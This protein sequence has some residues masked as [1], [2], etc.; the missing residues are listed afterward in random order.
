VTVPGYVVVLRMYDISRALGIDDTTVAVAAALV[1]FNQ[2]FSI[3]LLRTFFAEIPR[4][5]DEAAVLDRCSRLLVLTRVMVPLMGPG[6][7]TA[8][9]FVFLFA[10]QDYLTANI[11]TTS[12]RAPSRCSSPLSSVRRC[13]C[14]SRRA[15]RR[16]C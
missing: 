8:G 16:C 1:A 5:L 3:R 9:I 15:R 7:L 4:E 6:T 14:S 10:F 11:V 13:R 12:P 2:P